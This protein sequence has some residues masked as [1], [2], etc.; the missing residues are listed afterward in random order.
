M[1]T[2]VEQAIADSIRHNKIAHFSEH[3][4]QIAEILQRD[5][6]DSVVNGDVTE[7]WGTI[8]S[9]AEWR[10]HMAT[11][12]EAGETEAAFDRPA[13]EEGALIKSLTGVN[14][15]GTS[16]ALAV[17]DL[18]ETD[19]DPDSED[20]DKGRISRFDTVSVAVVYWESGCETKIEVSRISHVV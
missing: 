1:Y 19:D 16:W 12:L 5:C 2:N 7:Y 6:D 15:D 13:H 18:V 4:S 3:I 8:E 9:G 10:V 20:Y 11:A 14:A 17:G